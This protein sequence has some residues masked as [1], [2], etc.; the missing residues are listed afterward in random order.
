M[1]IIVA[2]HLVMDGVVGFRVTLNFLLA[3]L[4]LSLSLNLKMS[5]LECCICSVLDPLGIL[6]QPLLCFQIKK[7]L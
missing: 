4:I 5:V 7:D 3:N 6:V 1:K 2:T